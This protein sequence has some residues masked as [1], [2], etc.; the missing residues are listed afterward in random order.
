MK[1]CFL[2]LFLSVGL[3]SCNKGKESKQEQKKPNVLFIVADDLGYSDLGCTGSD[4]YETPNLDGLA[5]KGVRF[6][7]GYAGCQ[8]CSP[9]RVS[10]QTGQFPARHGVTTW[11]GDASGEDWRGYG[12]FSQLLPPEYE[13]GFSQSNL[14][15][16][17]A[18]KKNG[19]KTFFAGKW[20]GGDVGSLPED[21]GYDINIG[22]WEVG[23]PKGGYFDPFINPKMENR[24]PGENLSMRLADETVNFMR[25]HQ[26]KEEPF[27]AFLSFYAVHGPIQTSQEKWAKYREKVVKAGYEEEG[28]V[29]DPLLPRRKNQDHPVYAGLV[30]TMD[31]AVG[32]VLNGLKELGLEENTIVI[33]TSDN[34]G[35]SSGDGYSTSNA[36]LKG[37]KGQAYEGG[38]RVPYIISVPW[39]DNKGSW[40]NTPASGV[41][42]FPTVLDLVGAPLEPQAH[43]DGV[44]LKPALMNKEIKERPLYW[45]YPHYGNQGGDPASMVRQGKWKLMYFWEDGH[46][47]LYDVT[48]DVGEQHDLAGQE[49]QVANQLKTQL[50]DWLASVNAK[51]PEKD[52]QYDDAKRQ[53][54]IKRRMRNTKANLEKQRNAMYQEGWQ[55]NKDWWGSMII[56]D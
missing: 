40:N 27:F 51:F 34:G 31:D 48:K 28:F 17:K 18:M 37:G 39:L 9:S 43:V 20:H 13:H 14:T 10:L 45:H 5:D 42:F 21:H 49:V 25:N 12:Q 15:W 44:S 2:A 22:G 53:A 32:V 26:G 41:D 47:E 7:D 24:K 46:L 38:V 4:F 52:P 23:S 30:E 50:F 3:F 16:A 55:P 35:V 36:P 8:V 11:I 56:N 1:R 29:E 19:Y 6:S 54:Y 33:F